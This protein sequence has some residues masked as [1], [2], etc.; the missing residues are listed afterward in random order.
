M[1]NTLT[2]AMAVLAVAALSMSCNS[3]DNNTPAA[4]GTGN[5]TIEYDNSFAGNDLILGTQPNLT[6][7]GEILKITTAKYIVSNIE[8]T[9][10]NGV[11]FTYPKSQS[12][13]IVDETKPSSLF[14]RLENIPAGDYVKLKFGIG[15]D[16]AQ[17]EL[18]ASGQGNF[19]QQ[20]ED[21]DLLWNWTAGYKFLALEGTFTSPTTTTD[22]M[23]MV[24]TG[25]TGTDYNY[26]AV[27]IDLPTQALV[28]TNITPEIHVVTDLS[29]ITDGTNKIKL[30]DGAMVM[31]GAKLAQITANLSQA[32]TI[33]HV[34]ND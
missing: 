29:K 24:H 1:K 13:F 7:T 9:D 12:Y 2:K 3:D 14:V 19:L 22:T 15:V 16:Q 32:F 30:S 6:S 11:V 23:F 34:H 8:L 5:L 18:G 4:V 20:A 28:R 17:W 21:A 26:T 33:A 31:G 27:T 25:K 10:K